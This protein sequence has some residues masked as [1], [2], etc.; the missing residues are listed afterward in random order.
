MPFTNQA[1]PW[2]S[3]QTAGYQLAMC[4]LSAPRNSREFLG[5][6]RQH[7]RSNRAGESVCVTYRLRPCRRYVSAFM[8]WSTQSC[9]TSAVSGLASL[10]W[11][12]RLFL[13]NGSCG[14]RHPRGVCHA[15]RDLS[16]THPEAGVALAEAAKW[17]I[18]GRILRSGQAGRFR[19]REWP[20]AQ[21]AQPAAFL[22][23]SLPVA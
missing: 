8:K 5:A 12:Q 4:C 9:P 20:G 10:S 1:A 17:A 2:R 22:N 19:C 18:V 7:I 14:E 15:L 21:A 6:D 3:S 11:F 13:S 16:T 23:Q